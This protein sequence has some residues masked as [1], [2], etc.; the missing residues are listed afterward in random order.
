MHGKSHAWVEDMEL[1]HIV[2]YVLQLRALP[3][4]QI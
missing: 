3:E 1:L 2:S 4:Y